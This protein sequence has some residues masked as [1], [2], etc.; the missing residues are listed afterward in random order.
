MAHAIL[1]SDSEFFYQ[2]LITKLSAMG[3]AIS[4]FDQIDSLSGEEVCFFVIDL[5]SLGMDYTQLESFVREYTF[6]VLAFSPL[7]IFDQAV[8]LLKMGVRGYL[9]TYTSASN[10]ENAIRS[11]L[12]GGVWFDPGVIQEIIAHLVVPQ[13]SGEHSHKE[14]NLSERENQIAHYVAQGISNKE[15][16]SLLDIT[17]RTVKAHLLSCYQKVGVHDRI[18]L[19]L[20]IKRMRDA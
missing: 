11:V 4:R 12:D 10:M 8:R 3:H 18:S 6:A 1:M 19:A 14:F 20:W 16:A 9:N 5:E 17:E 7:P 2:T 15:I 13:G